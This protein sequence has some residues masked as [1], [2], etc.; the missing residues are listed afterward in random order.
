MLPCWSQQN[1]WLH[2]RKLLGRRRGCVSQFLSHLQHFHRPFK[3]SYCNSD[4]YLEISSHKCKLQQ[5]LKDEEREVNSQWTMQELLPI[6]CSSTRTLP[7][8]ADE[9]DSGICLSK[10]SSSYP[11]SSSHEKAY[12][13]CNLKSIGLIYVVHQLRKIQAACPFWSIKKEEKTRTEHLCPAISSEKITEVGDWHPVLWTLLLCT[14]RSMTA[15]W[16]HAHWNSSQ[17]AVWSL[18]AI[19]SRNPITRGLADR[20]MLGIHRKGKLAI[21]QCHL[22]TYTVPF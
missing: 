20:S 6:T 21:I 13:D 9:S 5:I 19:N 12:T 4:K 17:Q 14:V 11:G 15:A 8:W 22:Q 2:I 7:Y 18:T 1:S 16:E 3:E 10:H